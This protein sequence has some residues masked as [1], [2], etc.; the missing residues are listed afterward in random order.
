MRGY[1]LSVVIPAYNEAANIV[2]TLQNVSSALLTLD[3]GA[4]LLVVDDGS[5]DET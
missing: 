3:L 2:P 4:E 5:A 1:T